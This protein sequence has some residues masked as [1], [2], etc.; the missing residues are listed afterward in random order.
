MERLELKDPA[1]YRSKS[2]TKRLAAIVKLALND[3]SQDPSLPQY[4][5]GY[6]LEEE[7]SHWHRARLY[8]PRFR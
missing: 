7:H 1:G 3:I 4:R 5:Q 8:A 6:T 2:P